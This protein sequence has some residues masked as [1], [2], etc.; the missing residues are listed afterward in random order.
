MNQ[1]PRCSGDVTFNE[2]YSN[3]ITEWPDR[4]PGLICKTPPVGRGHARR[5][6]ECCSGTVYNITNPTSP[7]DPAYPVSCAM[8]CQISPEM[9]ATNDQNPYGWDDHFMCLT[10]GGREPSEW[11]VVCGTVTVAGVPMPTSFPNTP[12]LSWKTRTW[13]TNAFGR[14][15]E[16][17][18]STSEIMGSTVE[19]PGTETASA[20][21]HRV[22]YS[23]ASA[24]TSRLHSPLS[25]SLVE[26][27]KTRSS[28]AGATT[29]P[30][31]SRG[32]RGRTLS[33]KTILTV[34]ALVLAAY[35]T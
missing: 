9:S 27:S 32:A 12:V 5:F 23:S 11:E 29:T 6:A 7:D 22:T 31:P 17:W 15:T 33:A 28:V 19:P 30:T 14:L 21:T 10:D 2:I 26:A 35:Q 18:P 20:T 25:K 24:T 34:A 8:F 3:A 13:T 4:V 16:V 1:Q